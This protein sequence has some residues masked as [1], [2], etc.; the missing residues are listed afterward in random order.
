MKMILLRHYKI[1]WILHVDSIFK[2]K[3]DIEVE[4]RL[5]EKK[6]LVSIVQTQAMGDFLSLRVSAV[7]EDV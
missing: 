2:K 5:L 3:N 4:G 1:R 6:K 7:F